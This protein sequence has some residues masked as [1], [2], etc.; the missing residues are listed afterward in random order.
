MLVQLVELLECWPLMLVQL[1]Q[2][3][4]LMMV[5]LLES[6]LPVWIWWKVLQLLQLWWE[7]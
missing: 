4:V 3:W 6:T 5:Q 7:T 1:V 2:C